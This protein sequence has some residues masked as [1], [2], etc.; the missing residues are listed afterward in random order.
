M[1]AIKFLVNGRQASS[2]TVKESIQEEVRKLLEKEV[3]EKIMQAQFYCGDEVELST[4][5]PSLFDGMTIS[6]Q[7]ACEKVG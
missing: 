1:V 3:K 7:V 2:D 5:S 4:V 6:V